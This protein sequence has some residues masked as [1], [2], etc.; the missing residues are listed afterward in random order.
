MWI[1]Q[2]NIILNVIFDDEFSVQATKKTCQGFRTQ[3]SYEKENQKN[4]FDMFSR[5][6]ANISDGSGLGMS[7]VK[8]NVDVG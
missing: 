4:L 6:N 3:N 7:I 8:K 1:F 5:F 2:K